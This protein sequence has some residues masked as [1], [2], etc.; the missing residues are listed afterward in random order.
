MTKITTDMNRGV[1]GKKIAHHRWIL[2][3]AIFSILLTINAF[4][5][6]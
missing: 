2:R 6:A 5:R 4:L 1:I 3:C